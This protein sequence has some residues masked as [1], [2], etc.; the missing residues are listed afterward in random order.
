M[1]RPLWRCRSS[2]EVT[3][4][5][6]AVRGLA[7]AGQLF[8][9]RGR[10]L[11][12]RWEEF[13]RSSFSHRERGHKKTA[14]P[15]TLRGRSRAEC[16]PHLVAPGATALP[17]VPAPSLAQARSIISAA[18]AGHPARSAARRHSQMNL[19]G[20]GNGP[21]LQGHHPTHTIF[22]TVPPRGTC[23]TR[24]SMPPP[25]SAFRTGRPPVAPHRTHLPPQARPGPQPRQCTA[26][27]E[28]LVG[29]GQVVHARPRPAAGSG[30]RR[31]GLRQG[32]R[33]PRDHAVPGADFGAVLF[34][35]LEL[36]GLGGG[37]VRR[38]PDVEPPSP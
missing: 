22:R 32:D 24:R 19:P 18:R 35:G 11:V 16:S 2:E 15:V 21:I 33:R 28:S 30:P 34:D 20:R 25:T 8:G 3:G 4:F 17:G 10:P 13:G 1:S 14:L 23:V 9:L 29:R 31:V 26:A 27:A 36:T 12:T 6:P 38:C 7:P 37:T 5:G